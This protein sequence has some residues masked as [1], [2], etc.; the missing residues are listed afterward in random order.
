MEVAAVDADCYARE[1]VCP[2]RGDDEEGFEGQALV[3]GPRE[4]EVGFA[5]WNALGYE[6]Y[7]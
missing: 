3:V 5:G 2:E 1:N 7:Y 6:G 4:E